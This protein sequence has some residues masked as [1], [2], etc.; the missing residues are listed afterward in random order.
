MLLNFNPGAFIENLGYM[1][2]GM[3]SIF[4]VIGIIIL[5]TVLLNRIFSKNNKKK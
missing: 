1:V 3:I 2:T 5:V 4:I